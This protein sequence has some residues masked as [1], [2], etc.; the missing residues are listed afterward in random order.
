MASRELRVTVTGDARS[1]NRT[2]AQVDRTVGKTGDRLG[3]FGVVGARAL[4][5][6]GAVAGGAAAA[7]IWKSTQAASDLGEQINKTN[8]VFRGSEKGIQAWAKTT[9]TSIGIS[10]RAALE[11]AGVF[12]NMLVPMG[13]ARKEAAGMSKNMVELAA[14]MASFNNADPTEV[15]DSLRAGLSGETEPLRRFGVFLND[16]RLKQEALNMGLKNAIGSNGALTANAKAQATYSLILKDTAD[17]QGD[18]KNTSDSLANVQRTLKAQVEDAGASIGKF[19]LPAAQDAAKALSKDVIP[20]FAKAGRGIGRAFSDKDLD[21]GQKINRSIRSVKVHLGPLAKKL[22]DAIERLNLGSKFAA[23][24]EKAAPKIADAAAG[25]APHAAASFGRAF[26]GAGSWGRLLTAAFLWKKMGGSFSPFG[27]RA[28][29]AAGSSAATGMT[30]GKNL[31][32]VRGA[33]RK[34]GNTLGLNMGHMV[35]AAIGGWEIGKKLREKSPEVKAA[36]DFL[37]KTLAEALGMGDGGGLQDKINDAVDNATDDFYRDRDGGNAKPRNLPGNKQPAKKASSASAARVVSRAAVAGIRV[38]SGGASGV[39]ARTSASVTGDISGLRIL[40]QLQAM[41][42]G[43]GRSIHVQSGFR[44]RSEQQVLYNRYLNGTGNLA[45]PP[46]SSNHESGMAADITPGREVFGGVAG[47]YGLSFPIPSESWHVE[48][49]GGGSAPASGGSGVGTGSGT[50]A[51]S[52]PT[53]AQRRAARIKREAAAKKSYNRDTSSAIKTQAGADRTARSWAAVERRLEAID[54]RVE[55]GVYG[56]E[57]GIIRKRGIVKKALG[58]LRG[59]DKLRA[60]AYL[61]ALD[62]EQRDLGESALSD[63]Q[64]A[65][66]DNPKREDFPGRYDMIQGALDY[67]D[68]QVRAGERSAEDGLRQKRFI[69]QGAI[70]NPEGLSGEDILRLKGDMKDLTET[71]IPDLTNE[72]KAL[73][74]EFKKMNDNADRVNAVSLGVAW[75]AL[76]DVISGQIGGIGYS[77]RALTASAGSVARY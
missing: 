63:A 33:G 50:S 35:L 26:T 19:F 34:L 5:G 54:L 14:D 21:F 55:A 4:A 7:G 17:A 1:L 25:A 51:P 12:G 42:Q 48:A 30:S 18:F 31:G 10:Q 2:L 75:K 3:K 36:G 70:D 22:Y 16:A 24:F 27:R 15:L 65:Y 67:V 60:Q 46:G 11:A 49:G 20:A 73:K 28:G 52:G 62:E 77:G 13:F 45:A 6:I 71:A 43:T 59:N 76:A 23:A 47:K 32:K 72:I 44:S 40:P 53:P 38:S 37:G 74:E 57:E 69:L 9:G 68:L 41:A 58:W 64:A 39:R 29:E 56:V 61:R 66:P 8:V